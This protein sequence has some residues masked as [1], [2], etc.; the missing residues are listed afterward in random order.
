[1]DVQKIVVAITGATGAI[2]GVRLLEALQE[3]PG[4]ETHLILSGWA[5]KT[6]VLETSYTVE[7]VR[8]MAHFCHDL[9]N[10]GAPVASG[11]FQTSG[12]A[13][14]PCSMK[15]LGSIAHGLSE[16]L[17]I[18]AAD[19]MLKERK[20]LI[21]VPRET[22]LSAIHLEN[23]LAVNRAGAYLVPPMP[24]FYNHPATI[25]DLVNH[26]VGRVMDQFGLPHNLTRRWGEVGLVGQRA[27][28]S[29]EVSQAAQY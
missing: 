16:N 27:V 14:I 12:M 24:A 28:K 2:Y 8:K 23:M 13:V 10:V 17:I 7:A 9:R 5:E 26:L 15:T 25:D 19:V 20:K 11:S 18:R 21:L 22:P 3:C 1:M 6:I 29:N 4:V